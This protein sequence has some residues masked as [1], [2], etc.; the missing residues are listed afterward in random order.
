M[1]A[2]DVLEVVVLEEVVLSVLVVDCSRGN[3]RRSQQ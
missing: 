2:V 3:K 1:G